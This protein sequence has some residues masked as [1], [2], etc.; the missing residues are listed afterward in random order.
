M[1]I[2]G[3]H[4]VLYFADGSGL[5]RRF[6]PRNDWWGGFFLSMSVEPEDDGEGCISDERGG[7]CRG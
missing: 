1:V 7:Q 6:A 3:W 5:P 4:L 2:H